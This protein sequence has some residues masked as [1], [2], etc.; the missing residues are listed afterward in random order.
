MP[1]TLIDVPLATDT[2]SGSQPSIRTNFNVI[3]V[4][5]SQDHVNYNRTVGDAGQG[6]HQQITLPR[7]KKEII[8]H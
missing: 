5:F 6:M 3:S 2:L 8:W 7:N 4:A 1:S